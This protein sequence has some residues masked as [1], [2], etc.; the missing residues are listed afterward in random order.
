MEIWSRAC[1][2]R[3]NK[4]GIRRSRWLVTRNTY[5]ELTSTTMKTWLDWFPEERFGKVVHAAPITQMCRWA[6]EDGTKVELEMMFLALD[7]PEHAK[8]VK[9]LDITGAWM[10]EAHE[11]PKAILDVLTGRRGRFPRG[12][13]G[14]CSWSGV[15]M[16]TNSPDDD[17]WWYVLAELTR[18]DKYDFFVQPPGD[19]AEAENLNWLF[20]TP[21]TMALPLDHPTRV[22]RGALYY[23]DLKLGKTDEWIK[24]YVKGQYGTVH[25]GKPVYPEWNDSLHVKAIN[26]IPG[27]RL[28]IGMDFGLT[29]AAIITQ[30]DARGRLLVLDELCGEDMAVRQFL[31]DVLV[32]QLVRIYPDWWNKRKDIE[33]P[34]IKVFGDPA[35]AGR[36][37]SDETDCFA[38]IKA[39]ELIAVPARSNAWLPRRG[40]VAWF[41]SKLSNGQPVMLLDPC[42]KMLRKGFNGGYK[43]RRIQVV[44][45]ERF[46]D[47]PAKNAYSHPHDGL[48]YVAMEGGG[49][50]AMKTPTKKHTAPA[51]AI[52]D[53]ATGVLG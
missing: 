6:L 1:E 37:Q 11:Q 12:E 16:D 48:Q 36:A 17:H 14:G 7:R 22:A 2:Q 25:D 5:G 10:N 52:S 30:T 18:P 40:A 15:I 34:M 46:T 27:I 29:P 8:K 47:E 44:G 31:Q 53:S 49:V 9:S 3:A 4:E 35:G 33:K 42:C 19:S 45:E 21:E 24:V 26:P 43:Y 51:Y 38:E 41:L 13:D 39:A 28:D 32:P 20:Q 23:S 50:Q